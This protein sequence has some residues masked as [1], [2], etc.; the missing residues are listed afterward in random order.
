[1]ELRIVLP[2]KEAVELSSKL[3]FLETSYVKDEYTGKKRIRIDESG[4]L[5]EKQYGT[6]V[7][8]V[9]ERFSSKCKLGDIE[10]IWFEVKWTDDKIRFEV[11]FEGEIP[12][13]YSNY[14]NVKGWEILN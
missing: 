11:E 2:H 9:I 12:E 8:G 3:T 4:G 6:P 5:E 1:M 10:D 13:A 14:P 7:T